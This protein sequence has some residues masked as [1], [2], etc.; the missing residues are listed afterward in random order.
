[1]I[2]PEASAFAFA[3]R[4]S[5]ASATSRIFSRS[6]SRP[7]CCFA[8]TA[9]NCVA[10]PQSSGWSPSEASSVF[11]AVRVGVRDVDLVDRDD[12]RDVGRTCVADRLLRLRHH[13]V[14]GG[15]DE[16]G[17]VRHLRAAGAH[18][19]ER[20]V[21]RS[22][23]E[24]Q[25]SP[26]DV[27]LVRTDVLRDPAGLG[28]DDGRGANRVEQRRLAVVDV[29]HDRDDRRPR[30]QVRL[31]VFDDLGLLVVGGVLDGD[32][33]AD[34]GRDQLDL[35]VR[36]RLRRGAHLTE[37]HQDLDDLGHRDAERTRQVLDRDAGL[38]GDRAGGRR[39]RLLARGR[40]LRPV[41][42]GARVTAAS[43]A[44][45]DHHTPSTPSSAAAARADRTV[46]PVRSISHERPQCRDAG[47]QARCGPLV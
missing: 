25:L 38:D 19:G 29:A 28:V 35:F 42:R 32:L 20:L 10:P 44:A 9:A 22:V 5:S 39:G 21:A 3:R 14:V 6:S 12:D 8:E 2:G 30:A 23:E 45:L 15:D 47:A 43:V 18:R 41:A 27:G 1:M 31:D 26:V 34:L 37:P 4:S 7:V 33:A 11:H 36:E 40:L 17:D 13:A 24:R 46:R 16:H